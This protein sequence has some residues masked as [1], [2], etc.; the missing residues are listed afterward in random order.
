MMFDYRLL[1]P[2]F[3]VEVVGADLSR[4]ID[5]SGCAEILE[6]FETH[7]VLLFRGPI[8][9]DEQQLAFSR[10]FGEVQVSFSGNQSGATLFSRQSNID[11]ETDTLMP[12][13]HRQMKYQEG[14]RLW[15]S[16]SSYRPLGS[17]CSILSAHETPPS[18]GDTAFVSLRAAWD[19]LS[20]DMKRRCE[21]LSAMHAL[22]YSRHLTGF[23]LT[24]EQEAE[25]PSALHPLVRVNPVNGRKNLFIGSHASHIDG[26]PVDEGRRFLGDLLDRATEPAA[27]YAHAWRDGDVVVWD[28]RAVLHRATP[29]D[30]TRHRRLMQR[31]TIVGEAVLTL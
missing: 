25:A 13:D 12:P 27:V 30:A 17:K 29:F 9:D 23:S 2:R 20:D 31:T 22:S 1:H 15:H 8:L 14:N 4:T 24:P 19:G 18:G 26:L 16:D 3:G 21:G 11:M 28:N 7:S 10:W 6:A 5:E